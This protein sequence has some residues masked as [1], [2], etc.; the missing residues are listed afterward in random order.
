MATQ[1][2]IDLAQ[3][4]FVAYYG[5]PGDPGGLAFWADKFDT[6]S[7]LTL[8]LTQFGNSSEFTDNFGALSPSDL[9]SNL[10]QQMYGHPPDSGGLDFYLNRLDTGAAT[11]ASIAK[12]IADG[13]QNSDLDTLNNRIEVANTFTTQVDSTGATY[14]S[15]DIPSAQS[16]LATVDETT[17][18]VTTGNTSATTFVSELPDAEPNVPSGNESIVGSWN[19]NNASDSDDIIAF[20]FNADGTYLMWETGGSSVTEGPALSTD[21]DNPSGYQGRETG[22]YSWDE[23]TG[24]LSVLTITSDTNG[25][26]GLSDFLGGAI[27][28]D[29]TGDEASYPDEGQLYTR[30]T[31]SSLI[32][33]WQLSGAKDPDDD[34][35]FTF[36]SDG[37]YVQWETGGSSVTDGPTLESDS[38]NPSGYQG[39]EVGTYEWDDTTGTLTILTITS[40]TNGDWG[41]SDEAGGGTVHIDIIGSVVIAPELGLTFT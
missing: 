35:T 2:S 1:S 34:I 31:N 4:M 19:L 33:S 39:E 12:Q 15:S 14:S 27:Q 38:D 36:N 29:V 8:A 24:Q 9:I 7:D 22:T 17:Q 40:D 41:L 26:W 25:D 11:L 20:E 5:R 16:L 13:S 3:Q 10:Y 28:V 23:S 32:G 6:T 30:T 21:S 37:T 18:S